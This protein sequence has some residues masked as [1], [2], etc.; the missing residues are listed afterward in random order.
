MV[1]LDGKKIL[2]TGGCGFIGSNFI[3]YVF[4]NYENVDLMNLDKMGVGSR[5]LY[6]E[7][8]S[9]YHVLPI[10][11]NTYRFHQWDLLEVSSA[12]WF[13]SF[14]PDYVF[15]FAAESHVDRSINSPISFIENNVLGITRLLDWVKE[16]CPETRIVS[17]STD[18]VYGHLNTHDDPF[19]E[20][21]LL[22]PR[23]PYAASKAA[24]DLIANS[25][26]E[27]FGLNVITTR[28]CNNYGPHQFDE[29]FIP[30]IIRSLMQGKKIP[31]YGKGENVREWI[32]VED[33]IKSILEVAGRNVPGKVYNIGSGI[34]MNNIGMVI[35]IISI[36]NPDCTDYREHIEFVEDR[37]GHDFRYAIESL[38][39]KRNFE[40]K[41]F[42]NA[43]E[44][45]VNHYAE[46]Y[47]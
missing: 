25:Y 45:T 27:T 36:L 23:S 10:G 33:H 18:E 30:T 16:N 39:Y 22:N 28:C 4:N 35:L 41:D 21:S 15:H 37:K 8:L 31:V 26:V 43:M 42:L 47:E 5:P 19:T 11:S 7:E 14:K 3:E 29:K 38:N 44:E 1:D 6:L 17:V 20:N 24:A 32:H 40:L 46:K 13:S 2:V 34:E 9:I 12:S